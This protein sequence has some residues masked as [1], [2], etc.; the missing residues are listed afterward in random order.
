METLQEVLKYVGTHSLALGIGVSAGLLLEHFMEPV[1][2]VRK[3]IA[4]MLG[5]AKDAV[6]E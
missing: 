1:S 6:E 5:K 2:R 3:K 4:S